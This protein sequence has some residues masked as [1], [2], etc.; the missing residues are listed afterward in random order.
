MKKFCTTQLLSASKVDMF[1]PLRREELGLFVKSLEKAAASR[2]VVNISEQ[3]GE[4]MSNIVSKMVLGRSKDDR[5][6]LKGLTHDQ[7]LH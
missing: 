6:D 4:L 2:D 7:A 5:F 1:A 3:V